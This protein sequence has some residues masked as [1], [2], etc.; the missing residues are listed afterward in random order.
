MSEASRR[1]IVIAEDDEFTLELLVTQLELAGYQTFSARDGREALEVIE[2]ARAHAVVLD[3]GLPLMDGFEV[4]RQLRANHQFRS[5]PVL[6]L[7]AR[8]SAQEV[9][10][11]VELGAQDYMTKPFDAERLLDCIS[12]LITGARAAEVR[13]ARK[14]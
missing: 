10:R 11:A 9:R 8:Q 14:R 12:R 5:I 4:L 7:A 3:I 2:S 1:R 6:V 13:A